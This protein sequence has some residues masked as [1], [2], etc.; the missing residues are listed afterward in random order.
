VNWIAET[1]CFM[2]DAYAR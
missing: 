2:E 1:A